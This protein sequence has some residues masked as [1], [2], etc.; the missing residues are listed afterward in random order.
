[1]ETHFPEYESPVKNASPGTKQTHKK[2]YEH[3]L[4]EVVAE[5]FRAWNV[6]ERLPK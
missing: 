1:M 3:I 2:L 5:L 6:F 4:T